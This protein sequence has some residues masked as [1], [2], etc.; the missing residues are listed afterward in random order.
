MTLCWGSGDSNAST[1]LQGHPRGP[2]GLITLCG[3]S[4]TYRPAP[5]ATSRGWA[6]PG[7]VRGTLRLGLP[8]WVLGGDWGFGVLFVCCNICSFV[9]FPGALFFPAVDSLGMLHM[10]KEN[11]EGG[12]NLQSCAKCI[13]VFSFTQ[14]IKPLSVE[15][16]IDQPEIDSVDFFLL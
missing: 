16:V 10:H 15:I 14:S 13:L 5:P 8:L 1:E 2:W 12:L 4:C 6:R 9:M 7:L 11:Q 3:K